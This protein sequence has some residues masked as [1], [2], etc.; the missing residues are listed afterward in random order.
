MGVAAGTTD[1]QTTLRSARATQ[2]F[3]TLS[4]RR[5]VVRPEVGGYENAK[6]RDVVGG[7]GSAGG[8]VSVCRVDEAHPADRSDG[9]AGRTARPAAPV[10]R[11][12]RGRGGSR[13][14]PAGSVAD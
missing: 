13:A 7:S 8:A 6:E 4:I 1:D 12:G 2:R 14:H 5:T 3:G 11:R 10:H 9:R